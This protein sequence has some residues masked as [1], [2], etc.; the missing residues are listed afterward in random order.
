MRWCDGSY[1]EDQDKWWL[2]GIYREVTPSLPTLSQ[3]YGLQV[4][5][6]RKDLSLR[7]S[8]YELR[9]EIEWKP[10]ST[11]AVPEAESAELT[12]DFLLEYQPRLL[13]PTHRYSLKIELFSPQCS[14]DSSPSSVLT[15]IH[16]LTLEA[17]PDH[18]SP[19]LALASPLMIRAEIEPN[20]LLSEVSTLAV[21]LNGTVL[22]PTLWT[23]ETPHLYVVV[24]TILKQDL[25]LPHDP[26]SEIDVES[27][28]VG[29][30]EVSISPAGQLCVNRVP[31]RIAGVN[32]HE[33]HPMTGRSVS[34]QSM[35][36]DILLMKEFHFNAVR[37]SHYPQHPHWL[38]LCNRH[39]L[40]VIDECNIET[41]GFQWSGQA[42][43]YLS[44][45]PEWLDS[46]LSRLIRMYER[47]KNMTS[48]I[49]W[50]L[51][52]ES[53][54]GE[55]HRKMY[56]WLHS[57]DQT[58][59]IVQYESGGATS[60]V[61]DIICPMYLRPDWCQRKALTDPKQRPV[62]LCEYAHA[63]GN[64]SGS[65]LPSPPSSS[66]TLQSVSL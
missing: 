13:S 61:T 38:E 53:G 54:V 40:Y 37:L 6:L 55:A 17:D 27:C 51:G 66:L 21:S 24:M 52:N 4:Y 15:L 30:K 43:N 20:Y 18:S 46:H 9:S 59:R 32:R 49:G 29:F 7:I 26:P 19:H 34:R 8:D 23:A 16:P 31:I 2:S 25:H 50:S 3:S 33:F 28:E 57:R 56:Q 1:L 22:E 14:V 58:G 35:L 63:M 41:H 10:T 47:D 36:Q 62:I 45:R 42:V 48:V 39:G 60:E 65:T 12:I 5:L 11:G 64:S 44:S